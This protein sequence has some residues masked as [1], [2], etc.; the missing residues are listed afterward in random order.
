MSPRR[1]LWVALAPL[2]FCQW[3][4][5]SARQGARA[6]R[7]L[8][9]VDA[10]VFR[11]QTESYGEPFRR[12]RVPEAW[13]L[14]PGAGIRINGDDDD[15][16][17]VPDRDDPVVPGENDLIEIELRARDFSMLLDKLPVFKILSD[18]S[19]SE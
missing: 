14:E 3:L 12:R 16:D 17:G 4:P 19:K 11:P 10:T 15:G 2:F 5:A 6:S 13:E 7:D 1:L 18:E 9:L 8:A